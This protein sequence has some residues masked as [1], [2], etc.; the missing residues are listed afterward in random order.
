MVLLK[1]KER[2]SESHLII[3][4]S[5]RESQRET[6]RLRETQREKERD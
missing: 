3:F 5:D 1:N 4:I 6:E 2:E